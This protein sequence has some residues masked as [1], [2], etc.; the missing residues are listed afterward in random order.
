MDK[1]ILNCE[2]L[3]VKGQEIS[4]HSRRFWITAEKLILSQ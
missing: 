4:Y 2:N 1:Y 3:L